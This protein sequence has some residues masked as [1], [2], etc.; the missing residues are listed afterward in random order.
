MKWAPIS[1][2]WYNVPPDPPV[3]LWG[4]LQEES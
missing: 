1:E 2:I 3:K 4:S